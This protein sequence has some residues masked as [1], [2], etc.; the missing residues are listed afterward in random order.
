MTMRRILPARCFDGGQ[1]GAALV[2]SLV[3]LLI[4][5]ILS[6]S[7]MTT[8]S[9]ET[10]MAA[11]AQF[12]ENAFQLAETGLDTTVAELNAERIAAPPA[13]IDNT[14][15]APAPAVLVA[16]LRGSYQTQLCFMKAGLSTQSGAGS[17][18]S[19]FQT[20]FYQASAQGEA[21]GVCDSCR[22]RAEGFEADLRFAASV[23][24]PGAEDGA[25]VVF[26]P[27][28]EGS[29]A[30]TTAEP[31]TRAATGAAR[32]EAQIHQVEAS[33]SSSVPSKEVRLPMRTRIVSSRAR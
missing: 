3:L 30:T 15:A 31:A 27:A 32:A 2:V 28:P 18:A 29:G 4:L 22:F 5:T 12:Y 16:P 26:H 10:R 8:A 11:N 6:T 17:S 24:G 1:R 33:V 25:T 20:F 19:S 7:T 21:C 14:C 13:T 23:A 9:M